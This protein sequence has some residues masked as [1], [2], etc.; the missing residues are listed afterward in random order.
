LVPLPQVCDFQ[1]FERAF[2]VLSVATDGPPFRVD[3]L[4][5][6][7]EWLIQP[8][9]KNGTWV[10]DVL[11]PVINLDLQWISSHWNESS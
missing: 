5:K 10:Q 11:W 9:Q 7:A 4:L 1:C 3:V 8:G 2:L 6:Y